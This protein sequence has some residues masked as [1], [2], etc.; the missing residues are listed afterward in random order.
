DGFDHA[1]IADA[2]QGSIKFLFVT[3]H[4]A[5]RNRNGSRFKQVLGIF[6]IACNIHSDATCGAGDG[7]PDALL[8]YAVAQLHQTMFV[9]SDK[10]DASARSLFN[11]ASGGW[12]EARFFT[13]FAQFLYHGLEVGGSFGD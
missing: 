10:R 1:G 7:C 2:V 9:E 8:V 11:D 5:L 12:S 4:P 3:Y 13:D 6:L